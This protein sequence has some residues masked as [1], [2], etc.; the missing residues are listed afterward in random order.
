M[1]YYFDRA[2]GQVG[3]CKSKK[4]RDTYASLFPDTCASIPSRTARKH[5]EDEMI[6][7]IGMGYDEIDVP[8]LSMRELCDE[9]L[10][11]REMMGG[12]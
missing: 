11:L 8:T 4:T 2:Y 1:F 3:I 12:E 5:L 6:S 9:V 10:R 7:Y